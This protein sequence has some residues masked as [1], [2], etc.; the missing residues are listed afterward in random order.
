MKQWRCAVVMMLF[1]LG[2]VP[3]A[4]AQDG[5]RVYAGAVGGV[6]TLSAD[7]R[8]STEPGR[9]EASLYKPENG[10]ALNLFV[11]TH[12]VVSFPS[13]GTTCGIGTS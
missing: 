5:S 1:W 11:G 10:P 6:S 8:V 9:A 3:R 7:G 13:K 12:V 4:S 2:F